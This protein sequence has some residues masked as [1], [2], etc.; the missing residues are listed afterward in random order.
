M[1]RS[2]TDV[3]QPFGANGNW[4][5]ESEGDGGR[6][7]ATETQQRRHSMC[8]GPWRD[9]ANLNVQ[10]WLLNVVL[11]SAMRELITLTTFFRQH[12]LTRRC[13]GGDTRHTV[14]EG[15]SLR[16]GGCTVGAFR[17]GHP[18]HTL[19]KFFIV[20]TTLL[21]H[22]PYPFTRITCNLCQAYLH[23][24]RWSSRSHFRRGR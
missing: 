12:S 22:H 6:E 4:L 8:P 19:V 13:V 1:S 17:G 16:P 20:P 7:H 14:I 15:I 9:G 21:G 11:C 3:G 10:T 5:T 23:N 24:I 18:D 2:R